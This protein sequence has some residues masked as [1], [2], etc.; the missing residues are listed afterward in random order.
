MTARLICAR[1]EAAHK[2]YGTATK[3]LPRGQKKAAAYGPYSPGTLREAIYQAFSEDNSY[4]DVSVYHISWNKDK[5]P[6]RLHGRVRHQ[7]GPGAFLH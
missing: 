3:K 2:F 7:Q 4:R 5:A 1:S 6:L